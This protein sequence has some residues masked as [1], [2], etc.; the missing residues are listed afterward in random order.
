MAGVGFI[1]VGG[2]GQYQAKSFAQV[3]GCKVVAG[4][5][6]SPQSRE[7][8]ALA[9]PAA[10]VYEDYNELL[11][12]KNVNAVVISLPTFLHADAVAAALKAGKPVLCEKPLSLSVAQSKKMI[13][14]AKKAGQLLMVAHC[15]RFDTF[16][17]QM[18]KIVTSGALGQ[19]VIW[20]TVNGGKGPT[21]PWFMD[22]KKGGGPLIDGAVHNYDFANLIFGKP[23]SVIAQQIKLTGSSAVDTGTAIVEYEKGDQAMLSWSWGVASGGFNGQ[24]ILG[25]KASLTFGPGKFDSADLDKTKY[26]YYCVTQLKDNKA[27]L[28]RYPKQDMYVNQAR[29]FLACAAG[30]AQCQSPATEAI[31]AVAVAEAIFKSIAGNGKRV[32][33][34]W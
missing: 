24:D 12:D 9:H 4:A 1:G 16:W 10:R 7:A 23:V 28:Y 5:D 3:K 6:L 20:R 17:G 21:A 11:A 27:K 22:V 18:G 19:P 34:S 25:N 13:E 26:G 2:M 8:F 33:V 31:K 14:Q 29:H 15:R 30:K 32:K